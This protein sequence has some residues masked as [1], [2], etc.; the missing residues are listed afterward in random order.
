MG[1]LFDLPGIY[2]SIVMPLP[3][4]HLLCSVNHEITGTGVGHNNR[5]CDIIQSVANVT[6]DT[7]CLYQMALPRGES[8]GS[9]GF[10]LYY[11]SYT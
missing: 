7:K 8:N 4:M 10:D 3:H 5:R 11:H 2:N 6:W 9:I 1:G